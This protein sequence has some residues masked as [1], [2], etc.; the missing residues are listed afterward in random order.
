VKIYDAS[1]SFSASAII[2]HSVRDGKIS[3]LHLTTGKYSYTA[4]DRRKSL[5]GNFAKGRSL[6]ELSIDMQ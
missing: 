6:L 3:V 4:T 2:D 5:T 1:G